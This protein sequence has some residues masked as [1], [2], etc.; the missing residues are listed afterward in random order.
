M[1]N[2]LFI[3]PHWPAPANV[4]AF[5]TLREGETSLSSLNLPSEPIWLKQ[6]HSRIA[7]PAIEKNRDQEADASYTDQTHAVCAVRTADCLPILLC[8]RQ[9]TYVAAIHGGWR[10]LL[11]KIIDHTLNKIPCKPDDLMAW[12][13]P[14]IGPNHFEVG[15]EVR[16]LF[17]TMDNNLEAAFKPFNHRWLCDIYVIAKIQLTKRHVTQIY[18]GDYCTYSDPVKFYSY[19]RDGA[20]TGRM[21]SLIWINSSH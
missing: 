8:N 18:G 12:L 4:R 17:I 20:N 2:S 7:I 13:G 21:A 15:D 6:I 14:A 19:R 3:Q 5:C 10:G 11:Q 1:L 9:G 16:D